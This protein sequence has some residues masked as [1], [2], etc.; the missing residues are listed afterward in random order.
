MIEISLAAAQ[1]IKR[2]QSTKQKPNSHLKLTVKQGGCYGLFYC[3]ELK[4][5]SEAATGDHQFESNGISVLIDADSYTYVQGLKLDY[6]EDLMGGGFRF[7]NPNISLSCGCGISFSEN[8][9]Q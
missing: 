9:T 5:L 7:Q 3:L 8:S 6:S 2:I 1:E 4:T